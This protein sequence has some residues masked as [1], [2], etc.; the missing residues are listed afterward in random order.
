MKAIKIILPIVVLAIIGFFVVRWIINDDPP[1]EVK[2]PTN[3]YTD[4]IEKEI[5]SI[6]KLP[7]TAF[8]HQFYKDVE[9]RINDYFKQGFLGQSEGDNTQWHDILS[10]DL[11]SAY[12]TKFVDQAMYVFSNS[13]WKGNDL[14]FI[15]SEVKSLKSSTYL[16]QNSPI[17]QSFETIN[18]ILKKYDEINSFISS[19]NSFYFSDYELA[20]TYPDVSDKIKKSTNYIANNLDNTYV[21]NCARLKEELSNIPMTLFIK[22]INY[23]EQKIIKNGIRYKEFSRQSN[24]NS[25]IYQPLRNQIDAL[26]NDVYGIDY[27]DFNTGYDQLYDLLTKYNQEATRYYR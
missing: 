21:N 20:T 8:C 18:N 16:E 12:A 23:L 10:K 3:P 5:D 6:N 26:D 4:R 2:P 14:N 19:C 25:V 24:Y 15:R 17:A 11:Y 22:H 13:E 7:N 1:P 27:Y 9:Y